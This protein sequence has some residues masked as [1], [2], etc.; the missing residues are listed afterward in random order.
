ME[1]SYRWMLRRD[2]PQ[3]LAIDEECFGDEAYG[4]EGLVSVLRR[5]NTIGLVA[6]TDNEIVGYC[7]YELH[8]THLHI[9][10]MAVAEVMQGLGIGTLF[11]EVLRRKVILSG[12]RRRVTALVNERNETAVA[13]FAHNGY[14]GELVRNPYWDNDDDG[15]FFDCVCGV[16][17]GAR[18][19]EVAGDTRQA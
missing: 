8:A 1:S 18:S 5:M 13:F 14:V 11:L 3:V 7:I 17:E 12:R 6:Y 15:I 19:V 10:R 4:E 2:I 16:A 9:V